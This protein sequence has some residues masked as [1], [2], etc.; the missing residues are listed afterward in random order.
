MSAMN[1]KRHYVLLLRSSKANDE[2]QNEISRTCNLDAVSIPVLDFA[3]K[4]IVELG[5][6]LSDIESHAG[7][8]FTSSRAVDAFSK[9][10]KNI[11]L[12]KNRN[13]TSSLEN[14][15]IFVVGKATERALLRIND[16]LGIDLKCDGGKEGSAEKLGNYMKDL[17]FVCDDERPFLFICGNIARDTLPTILL[18]HNIAVKSMCVYETMPDLKFEENLATLLSTQKDPTV[19]VYFSPSGIEYSLPVIKNTV[20]EFDNVKFVAIGQTTANAYIKQGYEIHGISAKPTA[21]HLSLCIKGVL[22]ETA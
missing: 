17:K 13:T 8:I 7:I 19:I 2:Y 4:N 1:F 5:C 9:A 12:E 11:N 15:N 21:E 6:A 14:T 22:G 20:S 10:L 16:E 18:S 3:Y